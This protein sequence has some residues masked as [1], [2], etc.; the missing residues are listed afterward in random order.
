MPD[1]TKLTAW[2]HGSKFMVEVCG[3]G[4]SVAE[5]GEQFAWLGAAL[6]LSPYELGVACCTP[7]I[8]EIHVDTAPTASGT[9]SSHHIRCKVDFTFQEC[10]ERLEPSNGQ[11][12][13]KMFRNP[14]VVQG[15]PIPYRSEPSPG[16]EIPL[17]I[18]AGLV[19]TQ[20][21]N[22]FNGKLFIKGFS[23]M[24]VLTSGSGAILIWHLLYNKTGNRI[25]YL[26]SPV[27]YADN[28]NAFDLEKARHIV[29]WCSEVKYYAGRN[30]IGCQKNY[31]C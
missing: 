16:L 7:S 24:L 18:M 12:W 22:T 4:Y 1:N 17:D 29:G 9:L 3:T 30:H 19:R 11:C 6:H 26:D 23:A 8:G 27:A 28:A 14:V 31:F 15:Y 5:I 21:I 10:E 13:H 2:I 25:S 20:H